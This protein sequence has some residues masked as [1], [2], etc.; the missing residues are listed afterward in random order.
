MVE[1]NYAE[2][3][4]LN[5]IAQDVKFIRLLFCDFAGIRRCR[6]CPSSLRK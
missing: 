6:C 2:D 1:G 5:K 4:H 3:V